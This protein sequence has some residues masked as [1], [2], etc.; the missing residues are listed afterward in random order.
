MLTRRSFLKG[1]GVSIALPWLE[2]V[3]AFGQDAAKHEAPV[4]LAVVFSGN[5]FHRTE[6]WARGEGQGMQLGKVL[7]PL[8]KFKEKLVFIRGLYNQHSGKGG[9]HSAMTGDLL[10]GAVL[11]GG[12]GIRSG[13]SFDQ[14]AAQKTAGAT[15]VPSLVLGCEASMSALHKGYSMIYSSHISWSSPTTPTP[16][17]IFPALAFDRLFR[18]DVGKGDESVLDQVRDEARSL[19]GKVSSTDKAKLDEYL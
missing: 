1:A 18:D 14:L 17:E 16:L 6:W 7:E 11:E 8:E 13:I 4:R 19:G 9:I 15:K 2:S 5:G 10:T 12:G 3:R